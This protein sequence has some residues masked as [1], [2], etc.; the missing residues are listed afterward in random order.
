[1]LWLALRIPDLPLAVFER[2]ASSKA[3]FA[4]ADGRTV[5]LANAAA[6]AAGVLPGLPLSAAQALAPELRFRQRQPARE[7]HALRRLADWAFAYSPLVSLQPPSGL[8]LEI[9]GSLKLYEGLDKLLAGFRSGL[10]DLGYNGRLAVAPTPSAAWLLNLGGD[11]KPVIRHEELPARLGLLPVAALA[12]APTTLKAAQGLGIKDLNGLLALP[13]AGLA[14]R[15]GR[16]LA[17]L[18]DRA[19]GRVPDPRRPY[20]PKPRF[21]SELELPAETESATA[22]AF[23]LRRL[24]L[25]L[26]G[27]L[28]GL[29][30]GV[31]QLHV[32]LEHAQPP[33][34]A[35][36]LGLAAPG[37][38][39]DHLLALARER[40]DRV[41]LPAPVRALRLQ[42]PQIH[43]YTPDAPSLFQDTASAT[44][45]WT[46][47]IERLS[48]RMGDSAVFGLGMVSEHRPER[49]WR[50][51]SPGEPSAT[52]PPP[53]RP[54][55]LLPRPERL[56]C[57]HGQ[58]HWHGPLVLRRGPERIE[59]GWWDG[60]DVRRDYYVAQNPRGERV[61]VFQEQRSR[62]WF[63]HGLFS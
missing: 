14:R 63:L 21:E 27:F 51:V 55:W 42:A 18:L 19:L 5:L 1:M 25:E 45:V 7:E 41:K 17:T 39:P 56:S 40:L 37:R 46:Q 33:A 13:R 4:V 44:N 29:D 48:A 6:D 50:Y 26:G 62:D 3:P 24:L 54:L 36:T 28:L 60:H 57:S 31:Q 22:L 9:G 35:F 20:L 49:A 16:E 8:L 61:W 52:E 2:A 32:V 38:A 23:P 58:P 59:S 10:Q 30:S 12:L 53:E 47:L 11:E 15:L 34:T 43:P